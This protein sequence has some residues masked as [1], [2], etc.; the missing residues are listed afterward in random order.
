M[1]DDISVQLKDIGRLLPISLSSP[2]QLR[3]NAESQRR[4]RRSRLIGSS[5]VCAAALIVIVTAIFIGSTARSD[6]LTPSGPPTGATETSTPV[7]LPAVVNQVPLEP[8]TYELGIARDRNVLLILESSVPADRPTWR[9]EFAL[10][11]AISGAQGRCPDS[12]G[13]CREQ[14]ATTTASSVLP[15]LAEDPLL[16]AQDLLDFGR[17]VTVKTVNGRAQKSTKQRNC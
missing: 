2:A 13:Q 6:Q 7:L 9:A 1:T 11:S 5:M 17:L 16:S 15:E 12:P 4:L 8:S 10:Q 3:A 14:S